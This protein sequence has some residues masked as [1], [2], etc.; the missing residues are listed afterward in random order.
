MGNSSVFISEIERFPGLKLEARTEQ[1]KLYIDA[2]LTN[3]NQPLAKRILSHIKFKKGHEKL[4]LIGLLYYIVFIPFFYYLERFRNQFL[5][6]PR[7]QAGQGFRPLK[8]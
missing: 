3:M 4:L 1:N 8:P 5:L 2:F 7:Q 6:Q